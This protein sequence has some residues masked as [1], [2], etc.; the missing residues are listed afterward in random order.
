MRRDHMIGY[1]A[2]DTRYRMPD[3]GYINLRGFERGYLFRIVNIKAGRFLKNEDAFAF[4]LTS[5]S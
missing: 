4:L 2:D 1:L 5:D 3:A